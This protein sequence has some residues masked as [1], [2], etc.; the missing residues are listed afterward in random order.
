MP[1][2]TTFYIEGANGTS[3]KQL[4]LGMTKRCATPNETSACDKGWGVDQTINTDAMSVMTN[5]VD[6]DGDA[7]FVV[8]DGDTK[9]LFARPTQDV[10]LLSLSF[11][12]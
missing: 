5:I 1:W 3:T 9:N 11:A 8:S 7:Y 2:F 6:D 4:L 10:K 12:R